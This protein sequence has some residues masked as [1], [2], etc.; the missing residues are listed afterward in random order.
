MLFQMALDYMPTQ[1]TSVPC[2]SVFSQAGNTDTP[3]RSSITDDM[4]ES[5][6]V[7]K[8]LIHRDRLSFTQHLQSME[9]LQERLIE[10]VRKSDKEATDSAAELQP[11]LSDHFLPA[12]Y[13]Q[14]R[15]IHVDDDSDDSDDEIVG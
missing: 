2:E 8:Y 6:Q 13:H 10:L 7:L 15:I 1:A 3:H 11:I 5:L 4:F 14:P 12:E 9:T